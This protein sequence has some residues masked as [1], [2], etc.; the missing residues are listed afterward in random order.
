[1]EVEGPARV[2]SAARTVNNRARC[3]VWIIRVNRHQIDALALEIHAVGVAYVVNAG[4][5]D[6]IVASTCGRYG[7]I[8]CSV[9]EWDKQV[10]GNIRLKLDC[11]HF[12]CVYGHRIGKSV[13]QII[14]RAGPD[15][16]TIERI[17]YRGQDYYRTVR[18][19]SARWL[20]CAVAAN[21]RYR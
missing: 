9:L 2:V 6:D 7:F 15:L 13:G 18:I 4:S 19:K 20:D 5:N 1:M 12:V 3:D 17:G 21:H 8:N 16:D 10:I 11:D 14:I